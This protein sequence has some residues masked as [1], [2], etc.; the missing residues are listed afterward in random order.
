MTIWR[1]EES[2]IDYGQTITGD[3]AVPVIGISIF[4]ACVASFVALTVSNRISEVDKLSYKYIWLS[5]GSFSLGLGI[6]AMHFTGMLAYSMGMPVNYSI[7]ITI[8]SAIPAI[9]GSAIALQLLS[10]ESV[11]WKRNQVSALCLATCI[12]LM[13]FVG[14]EAMRMPAILKYDLLYFVLSI[15]IAHILASIALYI[16]YVDLN[17]NPIL[18]KYQ[19]FMSAIIMGLSISGMHYTAMGS[20][21]LY[22]S[23]IVMP[24]D[25]IMTN[26]ALLISVVTITSLILITVII[27]AYID[28]QFKNVTYLLSASKQTEKLSKEKY[29]DLV[30]HANVLSWEADI[31]TFQFSYISSQAEMISGFTPEE[32][33]QPGF[34][35]NHLH[36]DDKD[37]AVNFCSQQTMQHKD[38]DFTYRFIKADGNVIWF[39]DIVKVILDEK[40]NSVRLRGTLIDI[41]EQKKSE[42]R[43]RLYSR[44]L[45][46]SLNE[47]Y[48]FDGKSFK[49]I[50][51]NAAAQSNL[52]YTM[53]EL[54][55]MTPLDLDPDI[56]LEQFEELLNS[57][58]Q[59][60]T[61]KIIIE[62]K[63]KRKD[64]TQYNVEVHIQLLEDEDKLLFNAFVLDI[65]DRIKANEKITYQAS[66]DS[67][68]GLINRQEFERRAD[69]LLSTI[70]H[71][72]HEHALCFLDLDQFKVV[73]DTC[74][75]VAGDELLRQLSTVFDSVVRK[76]DT[77]ARLGG[78]EFGILME[79]CSIDDAHRVATSLQNAINDFHFLWEERIFRVSASIGLVS[80]N[81]ATINFTELLKDADAACYISK[82]LGRN[83]IHI[84]N[85]DN[86]EVVQ[87]QGEMQWI[88]KI[89]YALGEGLFCLYAQIIEPLDNSSNAHYELLIRMMNNAGEIIAPGF[90]LPA[91]ERYNM[92][93][94]IDQWVI[95]NAINILKENHDFVERMNFCSI[96]LSGQS[97]TDPAI[98]DLITTKL[99]ETGI[100]GNKICF[101]ITETAAISNLSIA[102]RFISTLKAQGCKF[103]LDDFGSGLS[104]FGYLKKLPVDYL[105]IDGIFVKDIADDPID[106]A[107]VKSI[108]E[109]GHVM[110]MHTIAEFVENDVIKG[111]LKEIG[112]DYVQGYGIHKPQP[113][114]ELVQK[115]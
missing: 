25:S 68:T 95:V 86:I 21:R 94:K 1:F 33:C 90:F 23:N 77:L 18:K 56:T 13:H 88:E 106:H 108:N 85:P 53:E 74:G 98:L 52:G 6:W 12:G 51:V 26:N 82:E 29:R 57:L 60:K 64:K 67:L 42:E 38:H 78:D 20:A 7:T 17:K 27:V 4:I 104:S 39:H 97:L 41:T 48:L 80:I 24:N 63:H 112:V 31:K 46:N 34:W 22:V 83:R 54:T 93:S 44:I 75:H 69:R 113:L 73:N 30:E 92:I 110:G 107:M 70:N 111:M 81:E 45:E 114:N 65:T 16:K 36:S 100:A 71:G 43:D 40:G 79:H 76:R 32:W 10:S 19:S 59:H 105:K 3:Y 55:E 62:A 115:N 49:F 11:T 89:N 102:I 8:L 2:G 66:H 99:E 35:A 96:N 109:I 103:A 28:K 101:E 84:F 15:V 50:Q 14:M 5:V 47:I 91:A 9:L 37:W 72:Q 87:R 58:R 61:E